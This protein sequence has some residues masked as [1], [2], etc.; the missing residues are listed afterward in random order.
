[1]QYLKLLLLFLL[2][3]IQNYVSACG[4]GFSENFHTIGPY[5]LGGTDDIIFELPIKNRNL[6]LYAQNRVT[7]IQSRTNLLGLIITYRHLLGAHNIDIELDFQ[8]NKSNNDDSESKWNHYASKIL[9][10]PNEFV[11]IYKSVNL[12]QNN[13]QV[14]YTFLNCTSDSFNFAGQQLELKKQHY[15]NEALERWI[16]NQN[17]VFTNCSENN[18]LLPEALA[19][20]A[21]KE[22]VDD[23]NYQVAASYFYNMNYSKSAEL[24]EQISND[25]SSSYKDIAFYLIF[26]SHFRQA[27]Y[28][29]GSSQL[30]KSKFDQYQATINQ[31]PY[32]DAING[33]KEFIITNDDPHTA[34]V[35]IADKLVNSSVRLEDLNSFR[36]LY[37][38]KLSHFRDHHFLDWINYWSNNNIDF[39]QAYQK[40]ENY[41]TVPWLML[42]ADK[43]NIKNAKSVDESKLQALIASLRAINSSDNRYIIAQQYLARFALFSGNYDELKVLTEGILS[44]TNLVQYERNLFLSLHSY[45]AKDYKSYLS[46]II[47]PIV[48]EPAGR[49]NNDEILSHNYDDDVHATYNDTQ[50][51]LDFPSYSYNFIQ[52]APTQYLVE[53]IKYDLPHSFKQR[54]IVAAWTRYILLDNIESAKNISLTLSEFYPELSKDAQRFIATQDYKQSMLFAHLLIMRNPGLSMMV[55]NSLH[56]QGISDLQKV[57]KSGLHENWWQANIDNVINNRYYYN[58]YRRD[59]DNI[60]EPAFLSQSAYTSGNVELNSI[61]KSLGE[62]ATDYFCNKSITAYKLDANLDFVPEM[63]HRCI[64]MSRYFRWKAPRSSLE[65]FKILH[66]NFKNNKFTK[67]TPY[68]Y[69]NH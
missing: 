11:K 35:K 4:S 39:D 33:F 13:N 21:T 1:M 54:L 50:E 36:Y 41:K 52:R 2:S 37:K 30:V 12:E 31:S 5:F 14:N 6:K 23:Y 68:H 42:T 69:Y 60:L 61:K 43:I 18:L 22:Q 27:Y 55:E 64:V 58:A 40:W 44:L 34:L 29:S 66:K 46:D 10:T 51:K 9:A 32:R 59:E 38:T 25:Q 26:R 62:D 57:D 7:A 56:R 28:Q 63:L 3:F 19:A 53:A 17:R 20:T 67:L 45:T 8:R 47:Q 49:T 65:A 15:E 24:F 16:M 48:F